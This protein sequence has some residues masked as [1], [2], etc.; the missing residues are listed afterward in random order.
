MDTIEFEAIR[1]VVMILTGAAV[2]YGILG[3]ARHL[4]KKRRGRNRPS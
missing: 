4:I 1:I 2:L 3:T